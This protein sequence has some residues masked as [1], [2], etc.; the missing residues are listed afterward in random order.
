[1][2]SNWLE[3]YF[4]DA[5]GRKLCTRIVCTT[6]GA[7]EFRQGVLTALSVAK[8]QRPLQRIDRANSIEI[9]TGLAE[10]PR[11]VENL[12]AT[13]DAIRCL[14]ADMLSGIPLVDQAI[15]APLEGTWA[16]DIAHGMIRAN[17]DRLAAQREWRE[18]NST[19]AVQTRRDARK[20]LKKEQHEKRLLLKGERDRLWHEK[21]K[22]VE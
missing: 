16:G 10:V 14:L 11:P 9:A 17:E 6:C 5:V 13:E 21:N 12:D 1:M 18:H 19:E 20:L 22:K 15:I 8:G 2:T 4:A 7:L 3:N